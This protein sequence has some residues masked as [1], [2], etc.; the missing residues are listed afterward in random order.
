LCLRRV[1]FVVNFGLDIGVVYFDTTEVNLGHGVI[2][3][4]SSLFNFV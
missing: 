4:G 3:G 1:I 2:K